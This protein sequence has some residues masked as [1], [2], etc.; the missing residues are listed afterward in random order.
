MK[1]KQTLEET[2]DITAVTEDAREWVRN[3]FPA[4]EDMSIAEAIYEQTVLDGYM[5]KIRQTLLYYDNFPEDEE[6]V[7]F[8]KRWNTLRRRYGALEYFIEQHKGIE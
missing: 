8:V 1:T 4:Q 3:L 5:D 6:I 7:M 2:S